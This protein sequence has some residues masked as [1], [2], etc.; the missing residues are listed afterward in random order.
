MSKH[1]NRSITVEGLSK[2]F[3]RHKVINHVDLQFSSGDIALISGRNGSGKT[4][5]LSIL[6][7]L[8]VPD[9]GCI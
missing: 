3:G 9:K 5:L 1:V 2:S 7:N 8:T 6:G 4:T